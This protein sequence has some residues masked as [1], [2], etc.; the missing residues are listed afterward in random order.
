[1]H[2]NTM[3]NSVSIVVMIA[4][5]SMFNYITTN[6]LHMYTIMTNVNHTQTTCYMQLLECIL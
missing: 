3:T 6:L 5:V 4:N 2:I 1:M